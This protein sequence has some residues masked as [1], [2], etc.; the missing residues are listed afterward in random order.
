MR[1]IFLNR[2]A[3][4][5]QKLDRPRHQVV[6]A[7]SAGLPLDPQ[8]QVRKAVVG[9]VTVE[10]VYFFPVEQFTTEVLLENFPVFEHSTVANLQQPV[11]LSGDAP[12]TLSRVAAQL[13]GAGQRTALAA[14]LVRSLAPKGFAAYL[15]LQLDILFAALARAKFHRSAATIELR[16]APNADVALRRFGR[17]LAAH[18]SFVAGLRATYSALGMGRGAFKLFAADRTLF[19]H[20]IALSVSAQGI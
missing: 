13:A 20:G 18:P 11:P 8:F 10:V 15:A 2:I 1:P 19:D 12:S 6:G 16:A 9:T 5:L 7:L 17:A 3:L 4:R 14:K